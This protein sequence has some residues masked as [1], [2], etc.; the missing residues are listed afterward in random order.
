M[1]AIYALGTDVA[2]ADDTRSLLA[3]LLRFLLPGLSPAAAAEAVAA[4]NVYFRKAGHFF[5]YALLGTLNARALAG[6]RGTLDRRD[7][8]FA[9][10]AASAWAAIDEFHQSF[11]A[12]RGGSFLD[13]L[14]DAAGAA[15]GI[16]LYYLWK[17]RARAKS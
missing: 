6:P 5:G 3:D 4:F 8:L 14:L 17:R 11:S 7:A 10:I 2:G 13:V 12:S 1:A 16:L 9:W 15:A